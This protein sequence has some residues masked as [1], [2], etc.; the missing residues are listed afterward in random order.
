MSAHFGS[1][2]E[3]WAASS[4]D[5][6]AS[7]LDPKTV[8]AIVEGRPAVSPDRELERLEKLGVQVL[9][10]DDPAYPSHLREIYDPPLL[11]YVLGQMLRE[12]EPAITIVG[13]RRITAYGRELA[14]RFTRELSRQ[15]VNI[16]S[17]LARG[18]DAVAHQVALET[19][20]RTTA[21]QACGL[22]QVYPAA[23]ASLARRIAEQGAIISDY[24][25][26]TRPKPEYFP[27][28]NRILAGLT[29]VTLVVE[30]PEKSG[31]LITARCANEEGRQVLAVP[32]GILS[33]ASRGTNRLIQDGAKPVLELSDL[34]EEMDLQ[35]AVRQLPIPGLD[36]ADGT[37][38]ALLQFISAEPTH[39]DE[40]CRAS[41]MPTATVGST[42]ALMELK[43]LVR[44]IGAISYVRVSEPAVDY[45]RMVP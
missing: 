20:G 27:R 37:E 2:K 10:I 44:Q 28:R 31:A 23:H 33:P 26:G 22:D 16:V 8:D 25:L 35:V 15:G 13:T 21:A 3:A 32:G 41:D 7:G 43:G 17:G 30:A 1:A 12:E 29:M 18:A 11:L 34:L 40:L 9:M 42:L 4:G 24:P 19:G 36:P 6:S 39:I 38:T 14:Q 5:L 45:H